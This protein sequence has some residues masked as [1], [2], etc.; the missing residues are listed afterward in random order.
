MKTI[1]SLFLLFGSLLSASAQSAFK[2][3]FTPTPE[4]AWVP[5]RAEFL[6][7]GPSASF[8]ILFGFEGIVPSTAR[9]IGSETNFTFE[10]GP[11]LIIVH[12]PGGP[13][14]WPDG[15]DG[16]TIFFGSFVVPDSLR[17]DFVNGR[18]TLL[19]QG[20]TV[21]DFRGAVVPVLAIE[22]VAS[23]VVLSWPA[24]STNFILQSVTRLTALDTWVTVT[25]TPIVIGNN[26]TVTD[27]A[28]GGARFYRLK[29]L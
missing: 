19:L 4:N 25:N 18:A 1:A 23:N 11:A 5:A 10:L 8:V 17:N 29:R 27:A 21:G 20:S 24:A 14:G 3:A 16:A 12:S 2:T 13:D 7:D 26:N 6:L 28:G 22:R 9:L 15:Y